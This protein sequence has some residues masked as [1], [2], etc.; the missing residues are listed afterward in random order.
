S[1]DP[2]KTHPL[3]SCEKV[4]AIRTEYLTQP[5]TVVVRWHNLRENRL[6]LVQWQPPQVLS[7]IPEQIEYIKRKIAIC[8][9][10]PVLKVAKVRYALFVQNE[11]F[12]VQH[13]VDL[14]TFH[15]II[16]RIKTVAERFVITRLKL[17]LPF[18]NKCEGTIA[19][20]FHLILPSRCI[21]RF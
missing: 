20:P 18:V 19:I 15:D 12:T 11:N 2:L 17:Y 10:A 6:P 21:E 1:Y 5:H 3:C 9:A 7:V 13:R 4:Q 16:Y 8:L 14:P